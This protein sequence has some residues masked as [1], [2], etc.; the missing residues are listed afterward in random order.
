M[1]IL[2]GVHY[3]APVGI[4]DELIPSMHLVVKG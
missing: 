3:A 4:D 1:K 2:Y